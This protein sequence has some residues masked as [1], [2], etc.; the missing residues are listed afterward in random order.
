MSKA[1]AVWLIV[2]AVSALVF[3]GVAVVVSVKGFSD[4]LSL[5]QHSSFRD[6]VEPASEDNVNI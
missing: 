6:K 2:F 4:L 3:F 1:V 5:L